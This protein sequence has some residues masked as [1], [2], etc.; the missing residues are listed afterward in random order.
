[1]RGADKTCLVQ[2]RGEIHTAIEHAVVEAVK[3]CAVGLHHLGIVLRQL[4]QEEKAKHPALAIGAKGQT[5]LISGGLQPC[6]QTLGFGCQI[7]VKTRLADDIQRGKAASCGH[8]V[9]AQCTRL[10]NLAQRRKV[11]HDGAAGTKG[12]QR[13]AAAYHF[14]KNRNIGAHAQDRLR[15]T[16]GHAKTRHDLIHNQQRPILGAQL[17]AS[18]D[19]FSRRTHKIHIACNRLDDQTCNFSAVHSK[20][21]AQLGRVV[22]FQHQS[23]TRHAFGYTGTSGVAK[24]GQARTGFH[25][26]TV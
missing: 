17:A 21:L 11:F 24:S 10:I 6:H 7:I 23:V 9:A 5:H 12:R 19:K 15:A 8:G 22:V 25:Q 1:M 14:A 16:Q 18:G 26:Q 20:S 2:R 3:Q 4:R 13:H